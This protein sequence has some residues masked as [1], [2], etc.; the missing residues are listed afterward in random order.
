MKIIGVIILCLTVM[1]CSPK[2]DVVGVQ[3]GEDKYAL[4]H[5]AKQAVVNNNSDEKLVC[6]SERKLGSNFKTKK[7]T[8]KS[9]LER[10]QIHARDVLDRSLINN[11]RAL[12][13]SKPK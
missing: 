8:T 7:C 5:D 10:D 3:V 11:N 1:A 12:I 4:D 2:K 13:D 9:K 6:R